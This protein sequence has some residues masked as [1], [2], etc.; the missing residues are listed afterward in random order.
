MIRL[1]S[2][3]TQAYTLTHTQ[4]DKRDA[5]LPLFQLPCEVE[6]IK[7][8]SPGCLSLLLSA[9]E[10]IRLLVSCH[11][12]TQYKGFVCPVSRIFMEVSHTNF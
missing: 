6:R 1:G 9:E 11:T 2:Y 10:R 5:A 3:C 4:A 7:T 12:H 8:T